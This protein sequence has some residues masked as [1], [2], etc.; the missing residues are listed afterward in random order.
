MKTLRLALPILVSLCA[1]ET[2]SGTRA[3]TVDFRMLVDGIPVHFPGYLQL[4]THTLT[5]EG[6]VINNDVVPGTPGGFI[7]ASFDLKSSSSAITWAEG[8]G[9]LGNPNGNWA[10]TAN[11]AFVYHNSG[12]LFN[13][14]TWV[15]AE[16]SG[17]PPANWDT[18]FNAV[19]AGVFSLLASGIFTYHGGGSANVLTLTAFPQTQSVAT[20]NGSAIGGKTPDLVNGESVR[21]LLDPEPAS[22]TLAG[23]GT[24]S[25]LVSRRRTT[26]LKRA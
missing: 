24:I 3:A 6:R 11:P 2:S 13:S 5:V 26:G 7:Q 16:T 8:T 17:M 21:F 9:F 12:V 23:L 25:M 15:I 10:S 4:G 18:Q 1:V 14:K 20:L 22:M 19:G